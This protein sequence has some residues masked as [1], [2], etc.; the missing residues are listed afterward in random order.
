MTFINFKIGDS[1][2][3]LTYQTSVAVNGVYN[4]L[5]ATTVISYKKQKQKHRKY[6]PFWF[7]W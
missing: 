3:I 1:K 2:Q 6:Y 5:Y 7:E 4:Y